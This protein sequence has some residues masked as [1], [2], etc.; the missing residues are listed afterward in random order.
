[1]PPIGKKESIK[2]KHLQSFLLKGLQNRRLDCLQHLPVVNDYEAEMQLAF[3]TDTHQANDVLQ[4]IASRD[5]RQWLEK[6][7]V[8]LPVKCGEAF[9]LCYPH[10]LSHKEIAGIMHISARTVEGHIR[11][12]L[13]QLRQQLGNIPAHLLPSLLFLL[14]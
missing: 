1:M 6:A 4:P 7:I 3:L 5:L 14:R 2:A 10:E 8:K 12:G 9:R 13:N 11:Q